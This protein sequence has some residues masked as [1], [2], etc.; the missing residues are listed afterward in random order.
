MKT[1]HESVC[2]LSAAELG[3]IWG[4]K[5]LDWAD[6][7]NEEIQ[8]RLRDQ[9]RTLSDVSVGDFSTATTPLDNQPIGSRQS[10]LS[11]FATRI[12]GYLL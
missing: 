12:K 3:E 7:A 11:G 6:Q 9:Y 4:G 2:E 5:R 10:F 8:D 1:N